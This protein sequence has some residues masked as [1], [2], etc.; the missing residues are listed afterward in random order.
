MSRYEAYARFNTN[1]RGSNYHSQVITLDKL[2]EYQ[3]LFYVQKWPKN[4]QTLRLFLY[5]ENGIPIPQNFQSSINNS[6]FLTSDLRVKMYVAERDF[7]VDVFVPPSYG[8][9]QIAEADL[10]WLTLCIDGTIGD[11]SYSPVAHYW[12]R[13]NGSDT[14][15]NYWEVAA[16]STS[17]FPT[18][19]VCQMYYKLHPYKA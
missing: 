6:N 10:I 1:E 4:P 7:P 3:Y 13:V 8:V 5:I 17:I 15:L 18:N 12:D 19:Q 2:G 11:V 16:N 14:N 9:N